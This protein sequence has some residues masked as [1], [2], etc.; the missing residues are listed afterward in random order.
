[1]LLIGQATTLS[2][3]SNSITDLSDLF[4]VKRKY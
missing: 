1:M 3:H 4:L 2:I